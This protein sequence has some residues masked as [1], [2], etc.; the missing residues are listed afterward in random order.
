MKAI[1]EKAVNLFPI[2]EYSEL[3]IL[4]ELNQILAS[5]AIS[6]NRNMLRSQMAETFFIYFEYGFGSSHMWVKQ[7]GFLNDGNMITVEF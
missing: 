5:I 6:R 3:A 4:K 2:P 1:V 7:V